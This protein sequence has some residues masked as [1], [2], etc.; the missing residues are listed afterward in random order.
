VTT[1]ACWL[2]CA[3][4]VAGDMVLGALLDAGAGLDELRGLLAGLELPGWSLRAERVSRS[5]IEATLAIVEVHDDEEVRSWST[6]RSLLES[7]TLPEQAARRSLATFSALAEVEARRHGVAI[8]EVHFHELGGHDA[9]I[10]V[11]GVA[12][13]LELL[14][15]D[16]LSCSPVGLGHGVVRSAHGELPSPAPATIELLEGFAVQ[17]IDLAFETATPTGAALLRAL[18]R[19]SGPLPAMT[20]VAQG[21]GAGSRELPGRANVVTALVGRREEPGGEQVAWLS[22]NLDDITG[23]HLAH[24]IE[25]LLGDGALDVWTEPITMKKGRPAHSLNLLCTPERAFELQRQVSARTGSLGVRAVLIGRSTLS[26]RTEAVEVLGQTIRLKLTAVG[27]KP[28]FE[29]VAAAAG[30]TGRSLSEIDALAR[31]ALLR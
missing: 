11:V 5:G 4:G 10:D 1:T 2:G 16:E 18:C 13:A 9:L 20:L 3:S 19:T 26:R 29:D 17:G 31:A 8:D 14:G 12:C 25:G 24:A 22:T 7:A 21:F 27:A 30:A 15:V 28:E 23:E 6:I